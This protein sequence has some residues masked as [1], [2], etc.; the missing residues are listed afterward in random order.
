[1][2]MIIYASDTDICCI[3]N[4]Y[5]EELPCIWKYKSIAKSIT[6]LSCYKSCKDG[7]VVAAR[8]LKLH[9]VTAYPCMVFYGGSTV[10][11]Q[12]SYPWRLNPD[13]LPP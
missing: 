13:I 11:S 5:T 6:H 3:I 7:G 4:Q 9:L 8:I 12:Y 10:T 1:M 2:Y